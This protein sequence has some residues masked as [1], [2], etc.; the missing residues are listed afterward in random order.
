MTQESTASTKQAMSSLII[1]SLSL[2][3][4]RDPDP[5]L[6]ANPTIERVRGP[7]SSDQGRVCWL[8]NRSPCREESEFV[9]PVAKS[10]SRGEVV[11]DVPKAGG[12]IDVVG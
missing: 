6:T 2:L 5:E 3:Q 10:V 12:G 9:D 7:G 4:H 1:G 11:S 8:S